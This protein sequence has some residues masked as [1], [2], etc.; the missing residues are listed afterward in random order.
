M[1]RCASLR[2]LDVPP[3]PTRHDQ[4]EHGERQGDEEEAPHARRAVD[5]G[6]VFDLVGNGRTARDAPAAGHRGEAVGNQIT[7]GHDF[8]DLDRAFAVLPL[9]E[10][11]PTAILAKT[12]RGRGVRSLESRADRWFVKATEA[13]AA[14]LLRELHGG[15][16]A[17]LGEGLVVR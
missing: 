9:R 14:A 13:E 16:A 1:P 11:R 6:S 10:E 5:P 8:D 7:D 17:R 2:L 3:C 4:D 15:E 12:V